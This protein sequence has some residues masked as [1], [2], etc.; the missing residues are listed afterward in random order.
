MAGIEVLPAPLQGDL[1]ARRAA[2]RDDREG[3]Q[4]HGAKLRTQIVVVLPRRR[5]GPSG[6]ADQPGHL[7]LGLDGF[8]PGEDVLSTNERRGER[9]PVRRKFEVAV[10]R[11]N[12]ARRHLGCRHRRQPASTPTG[13]AL[14]GA[15]SRRRLHPSRLNAAGFT[16]VY[17]TSLPRCASRTA[18]DFAT[19]G[20]DAHADAAFVVHR[21][22]R[23]RP[24]R[25]VLRRPHG[26][27]YCLDVCPGYRPVLLSLMASPRILQPSLQGVH[28]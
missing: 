21:S 3:Q 7:Q 24:R 5:H 23:G 17:H 6:E 10:A 15:C 14:R 25:G 20:V 8:L 2:P 22:R 27:E 11:C 16:G 1:H 9:D 28:H 26:A 4:L 13:V 19:T 18:A 12:P